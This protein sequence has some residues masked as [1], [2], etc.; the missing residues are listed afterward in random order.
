MA[1]EEVAALRAEVAHL[2]RELRRSERAWRQ[3]HRSAETYEYVA[4]R[5]KEMM[6]LARQEL[7]ATVAELAQAKAQA[8]QSTLARTRFLATISHEL[9]TP[10]SGLLAT[11]E[12]LIATALEEPQR[13]LVGLLRRSARSL[14]ELVGDIL[15]FARLDE[16]RLTLEDATFELPACVHDVVDLFVAVCRARGVRLLACTDPAL[17]R[18][19]R[20]D[21]LRLRQVLLNL[22][23]NACKFTSDGSVTVRVAPAGERILFEVA[24]TG[25][26][27][28]PEQLPRLF[29]P[30]TQLDDSTTRRFGGSGLGLAICR[31]LVD[32][33]GGSLTATSAVG[34]GSTFSFALPLTASQDQPV[35]LTSAVER[36]RSTSGARV[37]VVDDNPINLRVAERMLAHLGHHPE[38]APGGRAALARLTR[39]GID[40]V[41][42]DISMPDLDGYACTLALRSHEPEGWRVPVVA[43][44]AHTTTGDLQRA[45]ACGM[46]DHLAKPFRMD[47]LAAMIDRW[48]GRAVG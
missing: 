29:E 44:T 18:F 16:G 3:L 42:M 1:D 41:L 48:V 25:I 36:D 39:G 28:D 43:L 13:E 22:V 38:T 6:I 14:S 12:L 8:E 15:D 11:T 26:G 21:P 2:Q 5:G 9:R 10:L 17:P 30:F 45:R 7:E 24:D 19:V 34:V 20:G 4:E 31:R 35:E 33:M 40:L 27:I 32:L 37:L 46:D 23:D 47:E